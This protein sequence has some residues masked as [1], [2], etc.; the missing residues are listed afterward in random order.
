MSEDQNRATD[1]RRQRSKVGRLIEARGLN[2]MDADLAR[3][4]RGEGVER[5]SLRELATVFNE[6]LVRAAMEEA[7][8]N[9]LDGEAANVY[10][11]LS[12][13]D[14]TSGARTRAER[15]LD[16]EGVDVETLREQ[17]VSHQAIH[18]YLT[19]VRGLEH[20]PESGD[21]GSRIET[22]QRLVGRTRSVSSGVVQGLTDAGEVDI[23]EFEVTADVHVSCRDC[24]SRYELTA[25]LRRGRCDCGE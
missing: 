1:E 6:R 14:A 9:P 21:V 17:F 18:T 22:V 12:G 11:L 16:R 5:K 2:G 3:Y 25:F 23:G 20:T 10:D 19:D 8:M 4:W 15:R 7:G 24:N 13:D